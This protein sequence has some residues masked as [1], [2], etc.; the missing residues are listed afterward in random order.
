MNLVRD[1]TR[2]RES[3]LGAVG[4]DD[5]ELHAITVADDGDRG[6]VAGLQITD[7]GDQAG[8][9]VDRHA[10]DCDNEVAG[11]D[12]RVRRQGSRPARW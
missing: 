1:S 9:S 10:I 4:E 7:R 6:G 12:P 8:G 3:V 2:G 5:R 11:F